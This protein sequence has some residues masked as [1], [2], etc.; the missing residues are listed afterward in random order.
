MNATPW[1][2]AGTR[3]RVLCL[4]LLAAALGAFSALQ[5]PATAARADARRPGAATAAASTPPARGKFLIASRAIQDPRFARTV[6]LLVEHGPAGTMG[7]VINRPTLVPLSVALPEVEKATGLSAFLFSGGPVSAHRASFMVRSARPQGGAIEVLA[8]VYYGLEV[9]QVNQV[10]A[11]EGT[12]ARFRALAGHAGWAPGQL[13]RELE[14][15]D[16]HVLD[17]EA[18]D[19]FHEPPSEIWPLLIRRA[20]A[21]WVRLPGPPAAGGRVDTSAIRAARAGITGR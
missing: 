2:R 11:R 4:G 21:E 7:V 15:G 9:G 12:R 17:A 1:N 6:I 13:A 10:L 18:E 20:E 16:W 5:P 19:V 8:G 14:R 3:R